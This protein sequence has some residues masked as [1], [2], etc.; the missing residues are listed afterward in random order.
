MDRLLEIG[1][2]EE[3]KYPLWVSNPMMVKKK[4]GKDRVCIDFTNLN[5]ACVGKL[6]LEKLTNVSK[7]GFKMFQEFP[8]TYHTYLDWSL[9]ARSWN[10]NS[11]CCSLCFFSNGM[12][13]NLRAST[14]L[15]LFIYPLGSNSL[16]V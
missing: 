4:N 8:I 10:F 9:L 13:T 12:N 3:C 6:G 16:G 1:A 7:I 11:C 2:I 15:D 14:P 5:K